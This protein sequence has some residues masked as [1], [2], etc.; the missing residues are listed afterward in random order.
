MAVPPVTETMG[1][2]DLDTFLALTVA[3][4]ADEDTSL[5][6]VRVLSVCETEEDDTIV[7]GIIETS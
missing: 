6:L 1:S 2:V 7:T 5:D 4:D 3:L